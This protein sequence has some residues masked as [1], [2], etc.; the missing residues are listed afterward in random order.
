MTKTSHSKVEL[1]QLC[2]FVSVWFYGSLFNEIESFAVANPDLTLIPI[3]VSKVRGLTLVLIRAII[4]RL[5]GDFMK[6][7][8]VVFSC[9]P[10]LG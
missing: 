3:L 8:A 10:I 5:L 1:L 2:S 7:E 9:L 6:L 4:R